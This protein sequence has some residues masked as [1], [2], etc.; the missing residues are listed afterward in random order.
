MERAFSH[1]GGKFDYEKLV[2]IFRGMCVGA[3]GA[4]EIIRQEGYS[5]TAIIFHFVNSKTLELRF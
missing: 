1:I 2:A 5:L 4:V 3:G